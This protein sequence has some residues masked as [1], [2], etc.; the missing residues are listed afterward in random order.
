MSQASI[1]ENVI[2]RVYSFYDSL[3]D[4]NNN[5][6]FYLL[7]KQCVED[8]WHQI[9]SRGGYGNDDLGYTW[10][11][12]TMPLAQAITII[13][14][15]LIPRLER[16]KRYKGQYPKYVV[17]FDSL[18]KYVEDNFGDPA[19]RVSVPTRQATQDVT[20]A[21]VSVPT[22]QATQDVT[23]ASDALRSQDMTNFN[24]R[25]STM[26]SQIKGF[27]LDKTA[28]YTDNAALLKR[29]ED[30]EST[31]ATLVQ[32]SE[33]K[34]SWRGGKSEGDMHTLMRRMNDLNTDV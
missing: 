18:C 34:R 31:V 5:Q 2:A 23:Q 24:E 29:I 19:Q 30:L 3:P 27:Y 6:E 9:S 4:N 13:Q 12:S 14:R 1:V 25:I 7:M 11:K 33:P 20:H 10:V 28:Y 15:D 22:P 8:F 21:R 17:Y 26:E 16:A 32:K